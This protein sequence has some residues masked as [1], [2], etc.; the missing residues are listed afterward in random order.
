MT[1]SESA[2]VMGCA[3]D[4]WSISTPDQLRAYKNGGPAPEV[5]EYV[6]RMRNA[7]HT[8]EAIQR[9]NGV[10]PACFERGLYGASLDGYDPAFGAWYEIKGPR[11][12]RS[13]IYRHAMNGDVPDYVKWQLVHQAY[14][15]PDDCETCHYIVA[16]N[17]GS[18]SCEMTFDKADL[19]SAWPELEAAWQAF[20]EG[21][22][23]LPSDS[24]EALALEYI[25][26]MGE[27]DRAEQ[28]LEQGEDGPARRRAAQGRRHAR[29]RPDQSMKGRVSWEKAAAVAAGVDRCRWRKPYRGAGI[30]P[31][32]RY[33][34]A[35][36]MSTPEYWIIVWTKTALHPP[37]TE[38]PN[39][40]ARRV[41]S[42]SP[43]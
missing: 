24:D 26:A 12:T 2:V 16:P 21:R 40:Q 20:S 4:W 35:G 10:A 28:R 39:E 17:D 23:N 7:G 42:P 1:A 25:E 9:E 38:L 8:M 30:R 11:D 19:L 6:Q 18:K 22:T 37:A 5:S 14:C 32:P 41:P 13:K 31:G 27:K 34:G 3:P 29:Y 36:E 43:T 33:Q 15:V